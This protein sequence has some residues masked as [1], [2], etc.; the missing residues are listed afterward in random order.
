MGMNYY[1][2]IPTM[3]K[4]SNCPNRHPCQETVHI[5]KSSYGWRFRFAYNGGKYYKDIA[6]LKQLL[7]NKV[8][9]NED[10]IEIS[11]DDFWKKIEEAQQ[12]NDP[13]H[14]SYSE[15]EVGGYVLLDGDFC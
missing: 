12:L 7:K 1:T 10:G 6:G 4:C 14:D 2:R 8:I 3:V 5:G 9:Y 15:L 13:P 11:Q